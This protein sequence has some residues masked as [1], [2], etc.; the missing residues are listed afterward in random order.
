M[1]RAALPLIALACLLPARV[2]WAADEPPKPA[3]A[4]PKKDDAPSK[5]VIEYRDDKL[6]LHVKDAPVTDILD[7]LKKQ[8]S[9]EV[10][11]E[12]PKVDN[13]TTDFCTVPLNDALIRLLGVQSFT[14]T[15]GEDG[16]L[17]TIALKGGPSSAP[18][19]KPGAT[20]FFAPR[21][22]NMPPESWR[23]IVRTFDGRK[24]VPVKG[25]LRELAQKDD[26]NWDWL[27]QMSYAYD[28]PKVRAQALKTALKALE[29]DTELRDATLAALN[30]LDDAE[31]AQFVQKNCKHW[32]EPFMKSIARTTDNP[33][34]KA[35]ATAVLHRLRTMQAQGTT[36]PAGG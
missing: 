31:L 23:A 4:Q 22:P 29:E 26:V 25:R 33:E 21:D 2:S 15:Y 18:L 3:D 14:L 35:R 6:T 34:W 13:V 28:D 8:S 20:E 5:R 30:Q 16:K 1:L 24:R 10:K 11:G 9:A 32:S 27:I 7:E 19:P 17:K 12:A 36:P